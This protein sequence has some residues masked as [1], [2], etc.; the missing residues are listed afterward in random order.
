MTMKKTITTLLAS[1]VLGL[2]PALAMAYC[3]SSQH[4]AMTC[5]E[6]SVYDA[7]SNTCKVVTG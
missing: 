6:G 3:S 1:A 5:A 2:T 7:E 4:Q